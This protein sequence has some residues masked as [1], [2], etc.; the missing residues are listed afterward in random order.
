MQVLCA[1][2]QYEFCTRLKVLIRAPREAILWAICAAVVA[3]QCLAVTNKWSSVTELTSNSTVSAEL[4]DGNAD[5]H[6][7]WYPFMG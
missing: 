3:Q 6:C 1:R 5:G 4:H 7:C 2:L